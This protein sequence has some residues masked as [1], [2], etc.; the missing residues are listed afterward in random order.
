M[1][2]MRIAASWSDDDRH[3]AVG[4]DDVGELRRIDVLVV[5]AV[6]R[7]GEPDDAAADRENPYP[8]PQHVLAERGGHHIVLAHRAHQPA[9]GRARDGVEEPQGGKQQHYRQREQEVLVILGRDPVAEGPRHAGEAERALG[10]PVL[11][12]RHQAQH[13]AHAQRD[14]GEIVLLGDAQRHERHQ[15]ANRR[16]DRHGA[17]DRE[18]GVGACLQHEESRGVRA[19][20]VEPGQAEVHH[21]AQAPLE[22]ER[23]R[24]DRREAHQDAEKDQVRGHLRIC[25]EPNKPWGRK[26]RITAMAHSG[27]PMR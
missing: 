27:T 23:E 16:D 12:E 13:L 4:E 1:M 18:E 5:E 25:G 14:D 26:I 22:V 21:A 2:M 7:A 19:E 10:Q 3:E 24:Q 11:V 17:H 8:H 15:A 9:E 20:R 6:H